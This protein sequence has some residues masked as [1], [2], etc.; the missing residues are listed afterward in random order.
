MMPYAEKQRLA[1]F[2][3]IPNQTHARLIHYTTAE[4]AL[5]IINTKRFWM[6]NT[7]CMADYREVQHGF[8]IFHK[9]FADP[10]KHEAFT[11]ALNN[12][13]EG[14][15]LEAMQIF[16][17]SWNDIQFNT[18]ITSISEH[19]DSEDQY[20]RL[21][22][23]RA[24]GGSKA[25]V[26][27]VLKVPW[28]SQRPLALNLLFFP[29]AYLSEQAAHDVM[30]QV[31]RKVNQECAFL[32]IIHHTAGQCGLPQARRLSRRARMACNLCL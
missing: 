1:H 28:M 15:A 23:W 22:M 17:T 9:F 19:L 12:C 27:I 4:A 10:K 26:G 6:R 7:N 32:R 29:V 11:K 14:V 2:A 31:I 3:K 30:E 25:R 18:Y 24:L 13:S 5:K 16:N 8:G 21:S 20:G